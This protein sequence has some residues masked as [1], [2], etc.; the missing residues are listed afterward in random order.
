MATTLEDVG[1]DVITPNGNGKTATADSSTAFFEAGNPGRET[2]RLLELG[3]EPLAASPTLIEGLLDEST[4]ALDEVSSQ[5][6]P[7]AEQLPDPDQE[8][9]LLDAYYGSFDEQP[10][11]KTE[12][13]ELA[14]EVVIGTDDR[15]RIT[16]TGSY[17]WSAT[18]SLRIATRTGKTYIGTGWFIGPRTIMTA[19]HCV[20]LHNEGGWARSITVMPGRNGSSMPFG[21]HVA[22]HLRSVTGWTAGRQRNSDY[23]CII[24]PEN[25]R[26]GLRTGTFGFAYM[27]DSALQSKYLNLT[28]YPGDK[29]AGTQ[30]YHSRRTKRVTSRT[31]VYDIDTAGGQSG[32]A[33]YHIKDGKRYAVGVHTSGHRSGNSATRITKGVFN[34]M[35]SWKQMGQ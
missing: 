30:W 14:D 1:S 4:A 5:D 31:I 12:E 8:E 7:A 20:Y 23:G 35:K 9:N 21:A 2:E 18:V 34:L 33:V 15:R 16:N 26:L 25:N 11:G 29:P 27:G 3:L 6:A 17:P 10:P 24:L 28:G 32:S 22:T 19:G 13:D